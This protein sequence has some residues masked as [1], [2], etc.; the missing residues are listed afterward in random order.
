[1]SP[2]QQFMPI[3]SAPHMLCSHFPPELA[4]K[5]NS[6]T[7]V[8]WDENWIERCSQIQNSHYLPA[9]Q[10]KGTENCKLTD[11]SLTSWWSFHAYQR[12]PL[13]RK[14]TL[15]LHHTSPQ[16]QLTMWL[17]VS[18]PVGTELD[19]TASGNGIA[20][21]KTGLWQIYA[22]FDDLNHAANQL[23]EH[24]FHSKTMYLCPNQQLLVSYTYSCAQALE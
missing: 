16:A 5:Q 4:N 10:S 17:T 14:S 9:V 21:R 8:G 1:M 13:C 18:R 2:T 19:P 12:Q 22:R 20:H 3:Y 24:M 23:G 7:D 6:H 15:V 11:I